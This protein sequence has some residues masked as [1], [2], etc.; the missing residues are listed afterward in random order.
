MFAKYQSKAQY[1]LHLCYDHYL[2]L[3]RKKSVL[4]HH[5]GIGILKGYCEVL[6]E[7]QASLTETILGVHFLLMIR[8]NIKY[9]SFFDN[10]A[11]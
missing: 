6:S 5:L 7:Y 1:Y 11:L 9:I 10:A 8:K 4:N 2:Y 3:K